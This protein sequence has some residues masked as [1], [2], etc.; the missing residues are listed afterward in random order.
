MYKLR[1]PLLSGENVGL[2][3]RRFALLSTVFTSSPVSADPTLWGKSFHLNG[4]AA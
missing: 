2:Y 4:P 1:I 3:W